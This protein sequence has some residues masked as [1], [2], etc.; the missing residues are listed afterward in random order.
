MELDGRESDQD[1]TRALQDGYY[2]RFMRG[3]PETWEEL[4]SMWLGWCVTS[5][6]SLFPDL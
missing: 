4:E 6:P 3:E 2:L 5:R 1:I